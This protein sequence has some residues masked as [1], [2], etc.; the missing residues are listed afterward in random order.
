MQVTEESLNLLAQY[1]QR[2]LRP[3]PETRKQAEAYLKQLQDQ[4]GYGLNL[5]T[6]LNR[7]A[8]DEQIRQAAAVN[9][10]N[11]VKYRWSPTDHDV[12]RLGALVPIQVT[13][14]GPGQ[15]ATN[16]CSVKLNPVI[17]NERLVLSYTACGPHDCAVHDDSTKSFT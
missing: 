8:V 2:S 1:F 4:P 17:T 6:L 9:F 10:K 11:F 12:E 14:L 5:L 13:F 7:T 16:E 15:E 3:E